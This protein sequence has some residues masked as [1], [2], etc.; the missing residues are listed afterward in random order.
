MKTFHA[1]TV[2]QK[3]GKVNLDHLPFPEGQSVYVFVAAASPITAQPL[4]GSVLKYDQP[5]AP[6][7]E[8]EWEA[9]K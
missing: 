7:S 2:V 6:V 1:E 5:F 9:A 3:D 4:A 8:E